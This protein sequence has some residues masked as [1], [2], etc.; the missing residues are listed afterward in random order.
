MQHIVI[1]DF[2][3]SLGIHCERLQVRQDDKI[4][5]EVPLKRISSIYVSKPGVSLSSNLLSSCAHYGIK[6]FISGKYN[7]I[8]TLYG[9][10]QHAVVQ[11]RINQY[12]FL[13][14]NENR[15]R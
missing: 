14:K 5:K 1:N 12:Q 7:N 13:D 10:S 9:T 15:Y 2:G 4:I 8:C 3:I 11:N 6:V